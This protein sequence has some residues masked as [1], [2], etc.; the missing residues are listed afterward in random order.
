MG[1]RCRLSLLLLLSPAV[2]SSLDATAAPLAAPLVTVLA[3]LSSHLVP[4][5]IPLSQTS[6]SSASPPWH[7]MR[8]LPAPLNINSLPDAAVFL[9]LY[10]FFLRS[11]SHISSWSLRL[12]LA[13]SASGHLTPVADASM[14]HPR[15]ASNGAGERNH[16]SI[17]GSSAP[18][19]FFDLF[20][21]RLPFVGSS[22]S[23]PSLTNF[24]NGA[25]KHPTTLSLRAEPAKW[26]KLQVFPPLH[27]PRAN[28]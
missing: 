24:V 2:H 27:I 21:L 23:N 19:P 6:A 4:P 5:R 10:I 14:P 8:Y 12:R 17:S 3:G 26:Q 16:S 11:A 13:S 15:L 9:L 7:S 18:F 20:L 22:F 28:L 1:S 25:R